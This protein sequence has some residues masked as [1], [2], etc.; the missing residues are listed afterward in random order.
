M[1]PFS[2]ISKFGNIAPKPLNL[3]VRS[4]YTTNPTPDAV[5]HFGYAY[6]P[7]NNIGYVCGGYNNGA[8]SDVWS[9]DLSKRLWTRLASLPVSLYGFGLGFYNG[10]LY[11][12]G[13]V[14]DS[15]SLNQNM[16]VYDINSNSWTTNTSVSNKPTAIAYS[17][18]ISTNDG[19]FYLW[20]SPT[21]TSVYKYNITTN[22]FTLLSNSTTQNNSS[23]D[24]CSD[25][26]YL[27]F[28]GSTGQKY[29]ISTNT[30]TTIP[31][32]GSAAGRLVY[33]LHDTA[34]YCISN[35]VMNLGRYD[36]VT[37]TWITL[38][39][40]SVIT[41][42]SGSLFASS[43]STDIFYVLGY[44]GNSRTNKQYIFN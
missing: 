34:I 4:L 42:S 8:K 30:W 16:Y 7:I 27:Y 13:G 19:N 23:G 39:N 3:G 6:D 38:Y 10:K 5:N 25:G 1:L 33:S 28:Q 37:N 24:L 9:F 20:G 44:E 36:S 14:L 31:L 43:S 22:S 11:S 26:T 17:K 2:I 32:Y 40:N 18:F 35:N 41:G 21:N 12:F 29:N 15:G